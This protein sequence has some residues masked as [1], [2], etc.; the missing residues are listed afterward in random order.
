[1]GWDDSKCYTIQ[2]GMTDPKESKGINFQPTLFEEFP[3]TRFEV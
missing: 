2:Q 3:T 1:M